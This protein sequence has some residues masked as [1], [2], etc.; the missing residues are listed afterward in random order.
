MLNPFPK[1][2][3]CFLRVCNTSLWEK[4][5]MLVTSKFSFSHS[6]FYSEN[7]LPYASNLKLSSANFSSLE[8]SKICH[9]VKE[10]I[11]ADTGSYHKWLRLTFL[12]INICSIDTI[13]AMIKCQENTVTNNLL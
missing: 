12:M 10:L 11:L 6:V 4:E 3:P 7:F 8:E 9:F 2:K 1:N 13:S 5:K